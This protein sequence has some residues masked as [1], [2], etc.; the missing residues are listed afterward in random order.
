MNTT[1][2]NNILYGLS[3]FAMFFGSGNLLYPI[4]V[5]MHALQNWHW[6]YL[7]FFCTGI[8]LPLLGCYV[9][10][11][12]RGSYFAF[13][14]EAGKVAEHG[15]PFLAL[16]LI[17]SF[18]IIP[19]CI[20]VAYGG[21]ATVFPSLPLWAF[22]LVFCAFCYLFCL[23][24]GL[25]FQALGKVLTP[26]LLFFLA[27]LLVFGIYYQGKIAPTTATVVNSLY[28]GFT[29]GYNTMDLLGAFFIASLICTEM[30]LKTQSPDAKQKIKYGMIASSIGVVLLG[31]VYL[32]LVY[33]GAAYG[34][35]AKHVSL[36]RALPTI[37]HHLLGSWG[38][39]VISMIVLLS[40]L[41]TAVAM[42]KLY[43]SYLYELLPVK[44]KSYTLVLF[45]VTLVAYLFSCMNFEGITKVLVP[46]LQICYPALIVLTIL[47]ATLQGRKTF[48]T[49]VF[50]AAIA[51]T[52][53][54]RG[55]LW[56]M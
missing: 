35:L 48:K 25:I 34:D 50:Y 37:A 30:G 15:I 45:V 5:G 33:I 3:I 29:T 53:V 38:A 39:I 26:M 2:K 43:S 41:T 28:A 42:T 32:G 20:T 49:I 24:E 27:L 17:G 6:G 1:K 40:C 56:L 19:R 54:Y 16:S 44:K 23:K 4:Q 9:I 11:L 21:F 52:L 8:L 22:S 31:F 36:D 51:A 55:Y 7:G 10:M 47:S 14:G 46:I 12:H 18:G 13:F